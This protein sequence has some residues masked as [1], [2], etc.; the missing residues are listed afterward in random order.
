[1]SAGVAAEY[2]ELMI[3]PAA[4]YKYLNRFITEDDLA[5]PNVCEG[6]DAEA[7]YKQR[8]KKQGGV[9]KDEN[10][11]NDTLLFEVP[12]LYN[13]G[14]DETHRFKHLKTALEESFGNDLL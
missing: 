9:W 6:Q 13:K 10:Q 5:T 11:K 2:N 12:S 14:E 3:L 1:M 4:S 8:S 7:W